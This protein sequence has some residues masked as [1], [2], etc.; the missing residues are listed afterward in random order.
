MSQSTEELSRDIQGTRD[1]LAHDLDALQDRVS[2][3]AIVDRRK[4]AAR[5]RI[6]SVKSRVMGSASSAR[7][8]L[9]SGTSSASGGVTDAASNARQTAEQRFEGS[10]LG[11]GLVAF[12]AGLVI[13]SMLP[14]TRQEAQVASAALDAAQPLVD[15]ARSVGQDIA[16]GATDSAKQAAQMVKESA[17]DSAAKVKDEGTSSAQSVKDQAT[18]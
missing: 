2:P 18:S 10:P 12:G 1:S 13:A 4:A 8:S 11:A 9:S 15:E 5:D 17:A 14:A 3:S 7:D 16:S 6:G